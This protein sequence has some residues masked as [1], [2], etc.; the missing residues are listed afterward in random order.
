ML[1]V[2]FAYGLVF[3]VMGLAIMLQYRSRSA[4]Q[5]ATSLRYLAAF[6]V[7]HGLGE[8]GSVFIPLQTAGS[9]PIA[10]QVL[11]AVQ[12][13]LWALSFT[14]LLAFGVELLAKD[15]H[16]VRLAVLVPATVFFLWFVSFIVYGIAFSESHSAWIDA[17]ET[18]ERYLLGLPALVLT[19]YALV[20]QYRVLRPFY[21]AR[22]T[23]NLVYLGGLFAVYTFL[24]GLV[25]PY[26]PFFP[27]SWLNT[28]SFLQATYLPIQV[29]RTVTGLGMAYFTIH[30][31][32]IFSLETDR[33]LEE[34]ERQRSIAQERERISRDLHDGVIQ[35]IY[36]AGLM[37]ET[38]LCGGDAAQQKE[39]YAVPM[40]QKAIVQLN[41][42]ITDLRR[43]LTALEPLQLEEP[44][45][46]KGLASIVHDF[47]VNSLLPIKLNADC[48]PRTLSPEQTGDL[49]HVV[50]EALQNIRR[51]S[52]ATAVRVD[53]VTRPDEV[54][55]TIFDNGVGFKP[56][57]QPGAPARHGRGLR[58]MARRAEALGGNLEVAS[59][60]GR[61]TTVRLVVPAKG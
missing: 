55:V 40:V 5:L 9:S 21:P 58:N 1:E 19:T 51:H 14:A 28:A 17:G 45:L 43:Y 37:L 53:L 25:V 31:L 13:L 46:R 47:Q 32:K 56:I 22:L 4:F 7:L 42:T 41:Q 23:A 16:R 29:L 33:Q 18:W 30:L 50:L 20:G 24:G 54:E 49:Y 26:A 34:A 12:R 36:G 6:G 38:A 3:F 44:D 10:T 60:P 8:W 57:L 35:G 52:M 27:A 48:T 15:R 2:F 11:Q 39:T 61:G 59:E